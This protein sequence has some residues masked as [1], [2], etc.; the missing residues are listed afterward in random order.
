VRLALRVQPGARR[1]ALVGEHGERLKVAVQA[2]PTDGR[3]NEA[4]LAYLATCLDMRIGAL[5]LV[6]GAASRD[7]SVQV[8]CDPLE[9]PRIAHKL[10]A[11]A[12]RLRARS[13]G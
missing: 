7:K 9:A 2:P 13:G 1:C 11:A 6:A 5:R 4:L 8:E 10:S 3:A 12:G